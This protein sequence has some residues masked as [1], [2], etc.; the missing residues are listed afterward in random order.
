MN[1]QGLFIIQDADKVKRND[2]N[3]KRYQGD[4]YSEHKTEQ[5]LTAEATTTLTISA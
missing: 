5:D 1:E 3:K 4:N 2:L